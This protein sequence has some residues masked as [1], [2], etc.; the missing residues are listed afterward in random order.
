MTPPSWVSQFLAL[1]HVGSHKLCS[2][3]KALMAPRYFQLLESPP[4]VWRSDL[5]SPGAWGELAP[6]A[7]ALFSL[8][9]DLSRPSRGCPST[10]P[11]HTCQGAP[12][13]AGRNPREQGPPPE[14]LS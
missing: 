2:C 4:S 1:L 10:R 12:I 7:P 3:Y 11:T 5:S 8:R 14:G 13:S 6:S 9:S